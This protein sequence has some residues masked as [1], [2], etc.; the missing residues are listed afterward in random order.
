[1]AGKAEPR[2]HIRVAILVVTGGI[3]LS[4]LCI[5]ALG[6]ARSDSSAEGGLLPFEMTYSVG[7]PLGNSTTTYSLVYRSVWS[8]EQTVVDASDPAIVGSTE[9]F[10]GHEVVFHQPNVAPDVRFPADDG[11]PVAPDRWI[12][13]FVGDDRFLEVANSTG[14]AGTRVFR[15]ERRPCD[16]TEDGFVLES[17]E[18]CPGAPSYVDEV[19]VDA[20]SGVPLRYIE[21]DAGVFQ[22]EM[23]ALEWKLVD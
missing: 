19:T 6:L 12:R 2:R 10:D 16:G 1:M 14:E 17:D 21:V 5:T 7:D 23:K 22:V 8:W 11:V 9:T 15:F 3:V 18:R 20:K 4:A 13:A